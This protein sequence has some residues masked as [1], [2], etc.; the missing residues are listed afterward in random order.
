MS[1]FQWPPPPSDADILSWYPP[2]VSSPGKQIKGGRA[3][4]AKLR[5][6]SDG[7]SRGVQ[8]RCKNSVA[9]GELAAA[10]IEFLEDRMKRPE[11]DASTDFWDN[12]FCYS[13][14]LSKHPERWDILP[15]GIF[16]L[17]TF[18]G[19]VAGELCHWRGWTTDAYFGMLPAKV[20]KPRNHLNR[21]F[22]FGEILKMEGHSLDMHIFCMSNSKLFLIS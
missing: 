4:C 10:T 16:A 9:Q 15:F 19:R 20:K 6:Q 11:A 17:F 14:Q 1:A 21:P 8:C 5:W 3:N 13:L 2:T 18:G 22:F 12:L 7:V